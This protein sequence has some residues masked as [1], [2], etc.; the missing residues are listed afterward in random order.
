[1]VQAQ[2][3]DLLAAAAARARPRGAVHH[4]RPLGAH[5]RVRAARGDVRGPDRRGGV[6][7]RRVRAAAASVHAALAAA[8]PTIGDLTLPDAR[9]RARRR[10]ARPAAHPER[11][12]VPP[13]LRRRR[14][15]A[16]RR[17]T[18]R[19]PGRRRLRAACVNRVGG[20]AG[21]ATAADARG[22]RPARA[23]RRSGPAPRRRRRP[24]A[25]DGVDLDV[26]EG[27]VARARR[28][29][30][31]AARPRSRAR[32]WASSGPS[33]G[34]VRFEGTPILGRRGSGLHAY[35]RHVQMVFQDPTGALN[36]RQTIY[37]AVAEGP[38]RPQASAAT[39]SS[40]SPARSRARGCGRPNGSSAS[41]R[42]RCPAVSGSGS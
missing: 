28:R 32:S 24:R 2:V 13:A 42:T 33:H 10:P 22:P 19:S 27:E 1:M 15:R 7:R 20:R 26:R 11:V 30:R 36:P 41:T 18:S 40:S 5:V 21:D 29:V 17:S 14:G 31:A 35:R 8:F 9:R 39:R 23:L 16:A 12:P 3:L 4:P 25:V 34:E 37:E 6:E 38:A